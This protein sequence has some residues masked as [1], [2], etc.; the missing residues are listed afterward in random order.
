MNFKNTET[1]KSLVAAHKAGLKIARK[2]GQRSTYR[3]LVQQQ[4]NLEE[5]LLREFGMPYFELHGAMIS[6]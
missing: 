5:K 6:A 1:F 4:M 2:P 3:A